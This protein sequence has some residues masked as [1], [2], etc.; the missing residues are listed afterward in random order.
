MRLGALALALAPVALPATLDQARPGYEYQFPRDHFEHRAFGA[1]WWYYTGNLADASGREFGFELTFFRARPRARPSSAEVWALDQIYVAHFAVADIRSGRL[2]FRERLNRAGPGL[3]GASEREG[4]IWNGNWSATFLPGDARM[5][6]QRLWAGDAEAS[7]ELDLNPSKPVV[8][9]GEDGVSRKAGGFGQASHYTS[10]TRM[11]AAGRLVVSGE[12]FEVTG[13]AWMDHEFFTAGL[14]EDLAGWDWM[15]VQLDD[16]S[17]LMLYGL[18]AKGGGHTPYSGGTLVRPDG[19]TVPLQAAD[20]SMR[21]GRAW[22]SPATGASYPVEWT[23]EVRSIGLE[24]DV[25]PLRDAQE[26]V[27]DSD[28]MPV[29]W[30]GPVRYSGRR[31]GVPVRGSGY[32]EMTGYD[33]P[34]VMG[35]P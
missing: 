26:L 22:T 4:A 14:A 21:P 8:I 33:R 15:S 3:A 32:L 6:R 5:P 27:S 25:L 10:F 12:E 34:V 2:H 18:R 11:R 28:R 13:L 9:H 31:S 19:S 16:G 30:E 35:A 17:D 7:L 24:L 1:E 23:V 29:Y 20:L